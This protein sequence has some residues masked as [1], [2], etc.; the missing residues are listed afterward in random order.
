[1]INGYDLGLAVQV[2]RRRGI[3]RLSRLHSGGALTA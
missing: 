3:Y 1:M 2:R